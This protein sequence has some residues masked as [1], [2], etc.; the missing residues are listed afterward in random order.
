[1]VI[2]NSKESKLIYGADVSGTVFK[3]ISDRIFYRFLSQTPNTAR[4]GDTCFR[5]FMG[6]KQDLG[7]ITRELGLTA[8]DSDESHSWKQVKLKNDKAEISAAALQDSRS[9]VVPDVRGMGLKDAVY[10]LENKGMTAVVSGKGKV[11]SQ[12]IVPGQTYKKGQ[13]ILLMLN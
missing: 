9:G 10:L 2:Q 13:T 4:K 5:Q 12:S 6:M 8:R 1:V 11:V 7:T 3:K